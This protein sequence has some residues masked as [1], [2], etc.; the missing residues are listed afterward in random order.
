MGTAATSLL[1][2]TEAEIAAAATAAIAHGFISRLPAGYATLVTSA[3]LS[4]GEKQRVAIARVII[5]NPRFLILDEATS[6]LDT[7]SERLVQK[8]LDGLLRQDTSRRTAI[9]IAHRCVM[10]VTSLHHVKIVVYV[11]PPLLLVCADS[12]HVSQYY[13]VLPTATAG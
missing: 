13:G 3:Q 8:A 9:V 4:G 11:L 6:A 7:T 5:R 1:P 10:D 2:A 12:T